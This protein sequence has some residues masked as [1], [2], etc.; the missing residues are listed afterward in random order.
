MEILER[1]ESWVQLVFKDLRVSLVHPVQM[2][3]RYCTDESLLSLILAS[4]TGSKMVSRDNTCVT[5]HY[6]HYRAVLDHMVQLVMLVLQVF[7]EC[8]ERGVYLALQG[9]KV[10]G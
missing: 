10:K 3:Q 2:G 5:R 8:Q 1:E 9:P 4:Y 6:F 7:K